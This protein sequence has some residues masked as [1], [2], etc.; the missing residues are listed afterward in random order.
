[1][2]ENDWV[3][4]VGQEELS[5]AL[6]SF[7]TPY[8]RNGSID[9]DAQNKRKPASHPESLPQPPSPTDSSSLV[10]FDLSCFSAPATPFQFPVPVIII[11]P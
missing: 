8:P 3:E 11:F 9:S 6:F 2:K 10:V 4:R 1:M 5:G 7:S